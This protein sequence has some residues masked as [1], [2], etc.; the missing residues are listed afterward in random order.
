MQ[1]P[2]WSGDVHVVVW[3]CIL[4]PDVAG[5]RVV[6]AEIVEGVQH[7]RCKDQHLIAF[8]R[9]EQ[10]RPNRFI[11][12]RP[13]V[14]VAVHIPR[15]AAGGQHRMAVPRQFG[16]GF[17]GLNH[18]LSLSQSGCTTMSRPFGAY[19]SSVAS[20][21]NRISCAIDCVPTSLTIVN[22]VMAVPIGT[23]GITTWLVC[24][25]PVGSTVWLVIACE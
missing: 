5:K 23:V 24:A 10:R 12:A 6:G 13:I 4:L 9:I 15:I 22:H 21:M 14:V 18:P 16:I 20:S 17:H 25:T 3:R 19:G 11:D 1:R 7:L 8:E 2:L